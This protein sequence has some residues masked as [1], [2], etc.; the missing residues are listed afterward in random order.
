MITVYQVSAPDLLPT[1]MHL[2]PT[3]WGNTVLERLRHQG[4]TVRATNE[5][6][7]PD[8]RTADELAR[9]DSLLEW[10]APD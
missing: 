1:R 10:A 2:A 4:Y 3:R 8:T 6:D 7:H 9:R 5:A